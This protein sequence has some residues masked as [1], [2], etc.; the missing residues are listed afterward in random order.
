MTNETT[1]GGGG[2][3]PPPA[4]GTKPTASAIAL[5]CKLERDE[6]PDKPT[7]PGSSIPP[8]YENFVHLL[9][10]YG[11]KAR[12]NQV[13]KRVDANI[14]GIQP[15]RQNR[16]DV[17]L[18][19]L[20]SLLLRNR[21]S[22][23]LVRPYLVSLADANAY[24]PFGDWVTSK[25]WDGQSRLH[26]IVETIKPV[27]DYPAAF[28]HVLIRKWLLSIVAATFKG[29][30]FRARGVLTLQGGQGIGKTTWIANLVTPPALREDVIKLG[31]SW[32]GGSKDARLAAIRHRI[33][34]LGELESSFRRE[35]AGLKAFLTET[36][37]KIR[38]PYGRVEA[39]YPRSTIFAATVND[40]QFL[41]DTTGNSRFWT[42]E[43]ESI[44]FAHGIDMQQVFAELK[45]AF[46]KGEQWWLTA[47]EEETLARINHTH[48][49]LTSIEAKIGEALDLDRV[50]EDR[51]PRLT[52]NEVLHRLDITKPTNAQSKEANVALRALLGESRRIKGY[53][54]WPIPWR[55]EQSS[56]NNLRYDPA[57]EEY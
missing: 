41:L 42:I 48:R 36:T 24:D 37:D 53:N 55:K 17:V 8:T 34:E 50:G 38:P 35:M 20:E 56:G 28:C 30:G 40:R 7:S 15:G 46:D 32:D 52:A 26:A 43:V 31:H 45:V 4:I 47:E 21:M 25:A 9:E 44:D 5:E 1:A 29:M 11:I 27:A 13:K 10:A 6:F 54:R 51:L 57:A 14:P 23:A 2:Q 33:V 12:F 39:E 18:T 49:L 3:S 16:D 19:R 22:T